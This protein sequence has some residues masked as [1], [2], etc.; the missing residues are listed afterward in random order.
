L[1]TI[2]LLRVQTAEGRSPAGRDELPMNDVLEGTRKRRP[3]MNDNLRH[4]L[5]W[6]Q[7]S[8]F[9]SKRQTELL[10]YLAA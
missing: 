1:V 5:T 10:A 9:K 7:W 3:A 6:R 2:V 4:P 8:F